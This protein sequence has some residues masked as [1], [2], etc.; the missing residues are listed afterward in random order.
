[1][2][3]K[4]F[5]NIGIK[6]EILYYILKNM[7]EILKIIASLGL[8][9]ANLIVLN[10]EGAYQ[11]LYIFLLL[12][13][14]I[15]YERFYKIKN[16]TTVLN[17][18]YLIINGIFSIIC[19]LK[20][21]FDYKTIEFNI[22][23]T[24]E[25]LTAMTILLFTF[26]EA[27]EAVF[28]SFPQ[29]KS[30]PLTISKNYD[31]ETV[32]A[33]ETAVKNENVF[34]VGIVGP[35]ASGKSTNLNSF[36]KKNE[37]R[38]DMLQVSLATFNGVKNSFKSDD[39][40]LIFKKIYQE[41]INMNSFRVY[42]VLSVAISLFLFLIVYI[43]NSH[44]RFI[45]SIEY[46]YMIFFFLYFI[47]C[48]ILSLILPKVSKGELKIG[49]IAINMEK[50]EVKHEINIYENAIIS[51]LKKFNKN[52]IIIFEDLDRFENLQIFY[53]LRALNKRFNNQLAK[54]VIFI[55]AVKPDVFNSPQDMCKFFDEYITMQPIL[56][57]ENKYSRLLSAFQ[58]NM[59][60]SINK[61]VID[62]KL[63][64]IVSANLSDMRMLQKYA[65]EAIF[66]LER[67][68]KIDSE[69]YFDN[70]KI[71]C[72]TA[73]KMIYPIEYRLL[74]SNDYLEIIFEKINNMIRQQL[75]FLKIART[76]IN[77]SK[78][79]D[80][81]IKCGISN[82]QI[83]PLIDESLLAQS[84]RSKLNQ[85]Y[86]KKGEDVNRKIFFNNLVDAYCDED[87]FSVFL[88]NVITEGFLEEDYIDYYSSIKFDT[89]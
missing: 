16:K 27:N 80:M 78:I 68:K 57:V 24:F 79:K 12:I 72:M 65:S 76:T 63:I 86:D 18:I 52:V 71:I 10:D 20:I 36:E 66:D 37:K 50:L 44:Y 47:L 38:Y 13:F 49:D 48:V 33:I 89:E 70:N 29:K 9:I 85:I 15:Y 26:I 11:Y 1:M 53:E 41:I 31:E 5:K 87:K 2:K 60:Q 54:K 75:Q 83:K 8:S 58:I 23:Y 42:Y 25:A 28:P 45:E 77:D 30:L 17:L 22:L 46:G 6:R 7:F 81:M 82:Y 62:D 55:Y 61:Y 34:N 67:F 19:I 3:K 84:L 64:Q 32:H 14:G 59:R 39:D 43:I 88:M 51:K 35:Y 21:I 40:V 4:M 69:N 56:T 74:E 73:I